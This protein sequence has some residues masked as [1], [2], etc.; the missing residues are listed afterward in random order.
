MCDA[1][2]FGG[3]RRFISLFLSSSSCLGSALEVLANVSLGL[4][5]LA[6]KLKEISLSTVR[7]MEE[8][9]EGSAGVYKGHLVCLAP[10]RSRPQPSRRWKLTKRGSASP[11]PA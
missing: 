5:L 9:G 8:L 1:D 7:F 4:F 6:A 3:A 10:S 2:H 11:A